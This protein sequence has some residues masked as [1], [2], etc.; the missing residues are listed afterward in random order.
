MNS[1]SSWMQTSIRLVL[2]ALPLYAVARATIADRF[3]G[4]F[5]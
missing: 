4:R 3:V 1:L 5:C 2:G